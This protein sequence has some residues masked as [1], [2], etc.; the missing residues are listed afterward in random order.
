MQEFFTLIGLILVNIFF[1]AILPN[2]KGGMR[3]IL[4]S[5]ASLMSVMIV[6]VGLINVL[7]FILSIESLQ[8]IYKSEIIIIYLI[9]SFIVAIVI[10]KKFPYGKES[11]KVQT[12]KDTQKPKENNIK[13][14]KNAKNEVSQDDKKILDLLD[15]LEKMD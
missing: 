9:V 15:R 13:N 12:K 8:R 14:Q 3:F 7:E 2:Y 11:N 1:I 5:G 6:F 4:L 10:S